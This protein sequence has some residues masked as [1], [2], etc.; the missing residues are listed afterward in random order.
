MIWLRCLDILTLPI[1]VTRKWSLIQFIEFFWTC[2]LPGD[3]TIELEKAKF[4]LDA[5]PLDPVGLSLL[6]K[7]VDLNKATW[8]YWG[9]Q[10]Y[11][12]A[13]QLTAFVGVPL[14]FLVY[15]PDWNPEPFKL[16]NPFEL[17]E[18]FHYYLMAIQLYVSVMLSRVAFAH[19]L[20]LLFGIP[21]THPM[22]RPW[23]STSLQDYWAVRWNLTV[24][25]CLKRIAFLPTLRFL[26]RLGIQE[27]KVA[28]AL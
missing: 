6:D 18:L 4:L 16:L 5:N 23:Y 19:L 14:Y 2:R 28:F 13:W 22:R 11:S 7:E 3:R 21:Y 20:G 8:L 26:R 1:A 24:Q 25:S 17:D 9:R 12:L 15:K 27:K 10:A